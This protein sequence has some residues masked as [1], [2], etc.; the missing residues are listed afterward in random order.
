[1]CKESIKVLKEQLGV[2]RVCG[3]PEWCLTQPPMLRRHPDEWR[4]EE[5][6]GCLIWTPKHQFAVSRWVAKGYCV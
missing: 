2:G 1:M 3:L 4:E 6:P 5:R